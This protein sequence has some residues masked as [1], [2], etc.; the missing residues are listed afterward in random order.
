MAKTNCLH[1]K[2]LMENLEFGACV[3]A[4]DKLYSGHYDCV[5]KALEKDG[6]AAAAMRSGALPTVNPN[7]LEGRKLKKHAAPRPSYGE[8]W[9]SVET[10]VTEAAKG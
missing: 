2:D 7:Q 4:G 3:R 5:F 6:L 8:W 9:K 10:R 1:C